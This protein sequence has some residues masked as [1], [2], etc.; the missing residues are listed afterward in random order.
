MTAATTPEVLDVREIPKPQRH[1]LIFERYGRL[2]VGESFVL[3]NDHDPLHLREEFERELPGG[4]GWEYRSR[5]PGDV[6]VEITRLASTALP[7][8]LV[9]T[10]D[11]VAESD[12]GAVWSIAVRERDLDANI[13]ELPPGDGIDTHAGPEVDVL[14]HVLEGDGTLRTELGEVP[15]TA[16]ATIFL[17]RRA[18]RGFRAGDDG[19]RYLT[20]H[21]KREALVLR[22]AGETP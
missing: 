10:D 20:V 19:L 16:G 1:P 4:Y 7:R 14:I 15:L 22:S 21:R 8:V 11:L 13:I 9:H 12:G 3:S 17:P 18:Q 5:E 6:R 2:A